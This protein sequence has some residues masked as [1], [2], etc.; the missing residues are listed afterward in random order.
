MNHI[1]DYIFSDERRLGTGSFSDVYLG[2][3]IITNIKVAVKKINIGKYSKI[4]SDI[5]SEI[6]ILKKLHHPNIIT[7]ENNVVQDNY[8][9]II[10]EYCPLGDLNSFFNKK[11]VKE[12]YVKHY[13]IQLIKGLK[14]LSSQNIMHRD[15]KPHNILLKDIYTIKISDFGFA[16]YYNKVDLSK[17]LCGSPIYMAPEIMQFKNYNHK[18]DIWS[19]GIVLYELLFGSP[20]Y[21]AKNHIEL[22]HVIQNNI[23]KY[24][25]HNPISP[26]CKFFVNMLLQKDPRDRCGYDEIEQHDWITQYNELEQLDLSS[27]YQIYNRFIVNPDTD[28]TQ[29]DT[30]SSDGSSFSNESLIFDCELED[31]KKPTGFETIRLDDSADSTIINKQRDSNKNNITTE[32][33]QSDNIDDVDDYILLEHP[34]S[35]SEIYENIVK[36]TTMTYSLTDIYEKLVPDYFK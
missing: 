12:E 2:E 29:Y 13:A 35:N 8:L 17:T 28:C 15:I 25:S 1:D 9:Y 20:P 3:N 26:Q 34:I 6:R 18:T 30:L 24:P 19:L 23:I 11:S 5:Q 33:L 27:T 22:M 32:T 16:K 7:F 14:Y 36:T 10:L 21:I 4:L 31:I